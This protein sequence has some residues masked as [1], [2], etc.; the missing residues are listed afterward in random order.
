MSE[1]L[2]GASIALRA[3]LW[4]DLLLAWRRPGDVLNPLVFFH[5]G[6]CAV[7]RWRPDPAPISWR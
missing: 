4:R 7:F 1:A 6:Q 5:R 2:P 3:A